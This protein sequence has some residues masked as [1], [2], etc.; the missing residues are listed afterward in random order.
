VTNM[1]GM[2]ENAESFNQEIKGRIFFLNVKN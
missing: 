2:F 1:S